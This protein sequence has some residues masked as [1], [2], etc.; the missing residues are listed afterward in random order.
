MSPSPVDQLSHGVPEFGR[1]GESAEAFEK[2]RLLEAQAKEGIRS[3]FGGNDG[4]SWD[5]PEETHNAIAQMAAG[6]AGAA[7]R[8]YSAGRLAPGPARHMHTPPPP[9][10][11]GMR[12]EYDP[13]LNAVVARPDSPVRTTVIS[14]RIETVEPAQRRDVVLGREEVQ[15]LVAF[16]MKEAFSGIRTQIANLSQGIEEQTRLLGHLDA[17]ME[18]ITGAHERASES[19]ETLRRDIADELGAGGLKELAK[20][21]DTAGLSEAQSRAERRFEELAQAIERRLQSIEEVQKKTFT[22]LA[23]DMLKVVHLLDRLQSRE[24]REMQRRAGAGA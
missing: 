1:L 24:L 14:S 21:I 16:E 20:V 19:F 17:P 3:D 10:E 6:R 8:A 7:A 12:Y 18:A 2:R 22:G 15:Q 11:P 9:D 4:E 13:D 23:A 5:S